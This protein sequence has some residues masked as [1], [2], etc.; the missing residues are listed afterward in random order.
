[1]L[2]AALDDGRFAFVVGPPG[3]GKTTLV[4]TA[5]IDRPHAAGSAVTGLTS[6]P[7]VP[8]MR[9]VGTTLAG[10]I[11][12]VASA[13]LIGLA[14][15]V[16]WIDDVHWA[17]RATVEVVRLLRGRV[18]I[19]VTARPEVDEAWSAGA[20]RIE[21]GPLSQSASKRLA[22]Q[23]HPRMT[24]AELDRLVDV[25]HGNP[26]LLHHLATDDVTSPTLRAAMEVRLA[27]L[28]DAVRDAVVELAVH[29]G[30]LAADRLAVPLADM[31]AGLVELVDGRIA[32]QH[33]LLADAALEPLT[34]AELA[35]VHRTLADRLVP[36]DAAAHHLAG[37]DR[38][39]AARCARAALLR[40]S[41][42][43]A[44]CELL[45]IAAEAE[46][47]DATRVEAAAA[48]ITAGD[49]DRARRLATS[50]TSEDPVVVAGACLQL[51]RACWFAGD[52]GEAATAVS[53]GIDALG[54]RD[55]P[56]LARLHV[57]R[58]N[59]LVRTGEASA[60]TADTARAAVAVAAR[61]GVDM[62]R[63]HNVLATALAHD[64]LPGWEDLYR[65]V[66][67]AAAAA[68][69]ADT[70]CSAAYF[71]ASHLGFAGRYAEAVE[72][73]EASSARATALGEVTWRDHMTLASITDRFMAGG[74]PAALVDDAR[75]FIEARPVFR[76]RAQAEL[77]LAL[78]LGD[79]ADF[80][81]AT[82]GVLAA[83]EM[84]TSVED[85]SILLAAA[86]ELFWMAGELPRVLEFGE[87]AAELGPGWFGITAA[88]A[89]AAALARFELG[90]PV[91]AGIDRPKVPIF[92]TFQVEIDGL[93]AWSDGDSGRADRACWMTPSPGGSGADPSATGSGPSGRRA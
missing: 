55:H 29:A 54:D 32:L 26:L 51:T 16:L 30:P 3:V 17:D 13:V 91:T 86:T 83:L 67:P 27:A 69:D 18:P 23:L 43:G 73:L 28:P 46:D 44:R 33:A 63:A 82:H 76:N 25:A 12:T 59:Q 22:R 66:I 65:Q 40:P 58:A 35:R 19:V 38:D 45:A 11:E 2:S 53:T 36:E 4:R 9:A 52:I 81:R 60:S 48:S 93:R 50:V 7:F 42:P 8:L 37:G 15:R 61:V 10:D 14:G 57:E 78:S 1:M 77:A 79:L 5:L 87:L 85:R 71:L 80:E 88:A 89:A 41:D 49:W 70:E 20:C 21:I 24:D 75:R 68:G 6:R 74:D 34:A 31:P 47:D 39:A 56:L 72:L 64:G 84:M 90:Q 62:P 92:E